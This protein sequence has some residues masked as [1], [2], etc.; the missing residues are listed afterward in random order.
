[1]PRGVRPGSLET[2]NSR[3]PGPWRAIFTPQKVSMRT[4]DPRSKCVH[5]L[6]GAS[7]SPGSGVFHLWQI[8]H[9]LSSYHVGKDLS[10]EG[11]Q[12]II[13]HRTTSER[14]VSDP[15]HIIYT[16]GVKL[17]QKIIKTQK[18][19]VKKKNPPKT[20]RYLYTMEYYSAIKKNETKPFAATW[21]DLEIVTLAE[22]SQTEKDKYYMILLIYG[23]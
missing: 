4:Q 2:T 7:P 16:F 9:L 20:Q 14:S 10:K 12:L 1:M 18:C 21:M 13:Y 15:E 5:P 22:V 3:L 6:S 23:I 17:I 11:H 8:F 19:R